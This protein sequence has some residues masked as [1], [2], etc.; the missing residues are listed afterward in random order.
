MSTTKHVRDMTDN[1][2]ADAKR[3][4]RRAAPIA[5]PPTPAKPIS[6]MSKGEYAA[7]KRTLLRP[8]R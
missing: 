1:E 5:A 2:Y 8:A 6:E 7:A 3:A 4:V